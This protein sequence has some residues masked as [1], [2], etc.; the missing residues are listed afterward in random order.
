M[1]K[2]DKERAFG[3]AL[4]TAG[5]IFVG[6]LIHD[7]KKI[8]K[9]AAEKEAAI[10]EAEAQAEETV[11]AAE[12][13][14]PVEEAPAEEAA[15]EVVEEAAEA[16]A[17]AEETAEEPAAEEAVE[18][19]T[20]AAPVEEAKPS[21]NDIVGKKEEAQDDKTDKLLGDIFLLNRKK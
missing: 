21:L 9:L 12:E 3:F 2:I 11:E 5:S 1:K 17:A 19:T 10:A 18:E 13:A 15:E 6:K 20:E 7:V 14:A 16:E 8:K 4:L